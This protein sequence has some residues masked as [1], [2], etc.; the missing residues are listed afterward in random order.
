MPRVREEVEGLDLLQLEAAGL[1]D[2]EVADLGCGVAG[3]V[4]DPGRPEGDQL[5]EELRRAALSRGIDHH[6]GLG[7]GEF[8]VGEDRLGRGGEEA[9]VGDA[10]GLGIAAR[11][12]GGGLADL[13][14]GDL[15]EVLGQGQREQARAAV[16]IDEKP[17]SSRAGLG[18]DVAGEGGEDEG[19]VLEEIPGEEVEGKFA[20]VL[21]VTSDTKSCRHDAARQV[22]RNH[23][24]R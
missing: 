9:G 12:V 2:R 14:A 18:G 19:I 15:F 5:V 7:G 11:P 17:G 10:V 1:E 22:R 6:R 23:R 24:R 8:D 20:D 3:D 13:D 4:D 21:E 16:G